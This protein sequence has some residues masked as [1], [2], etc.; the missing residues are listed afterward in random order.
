[1]KKTPLSLKAAFIPQYGKHQT[2]PNTE[3]ASIY[4]RRNGT[5]DL[6]AA[7]SQ[8]RRQIMKFPSQFIPTMN[9]YFSKIKRTHLLWLLRQSAKGMLDQ[10]HL[11]NNDSRCLYVEQRPRR[12]PE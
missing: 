9:A 5:P 3:R 12:F 4:V 10:N 8:A 2:G 1:M 6:D 11:S 7:Q